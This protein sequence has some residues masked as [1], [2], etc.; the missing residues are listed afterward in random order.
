[1]T[2]MKSMNTGASG[3]R[4]HG[5]AL[6]TTSDN[7]AN[8]NTVGF[9]RQRAIFQDVL[10]RSIGG[11]ASPMP[12][13]GSRVG[14]IQQMWSQGALLTTEAPTDLALSGDGFFVVDG[15]VGGAPGRF[16]TRAGQFAINSDGLLANP[17]GLRLQGYTAAPDGTIGG[18]LGDLQVA[19]QTIP[20]NATTSVDL[21]VQLNSDTAAR[22]DAWD[23]TNPSNT[24]DWSTSVT[25]Y[26]SLG[27]SHETTVYFRRE[28]GA[29]SWNWFALTDGANID[30]GTAGVPFEGASGTL[31][32][33]TDGSLQTDTTTTSNWDFLGA[34][35]GQTIDFDFGESIIEG[36]TG[37]TGSTS[38]DGEDTQNGLFQD[39]YSAGT[40]AGISVGGDGMIEGVFSN[41]QRR[42]LGQV[43]VAAFTS[44]DGLERGGS[45]LWSESRDSG[46]ALIAGASTGGRGAV[47]SGA[48]E[49]SNV[50]LGQ[51]FVDM[52]GFQRGFQANSR[53]I[54][55][56]DEMYGELINL[57]R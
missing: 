37:L 56:A 24:S 54:T 49:Q 13:A 26:D 45:N 21:S 39:G 36:G 41:G 40:V 19:G 8:T 22:T 2:I 52:I 5:Q 47:V 42:L 18:E 48:L 15:N 46:Q 28:G 17:D 29:G 27:N 57:K 30:G 44:V 7:I 14:H 32:F 51:E 16:Y 43:A 35:A 11:G 53:V 3:L 4:A 55:T 50:D 20:A 6:A 38:F 12:G 31:A 23:P 34:A 25:V 9:K 33:N 1:M 10:G